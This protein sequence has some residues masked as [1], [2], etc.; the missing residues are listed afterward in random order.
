ML[1]SL[2]SSISG[3]QNHQT[4]MDIIG[5]N[6]ANVNTTGFKSGRITFE[7]SFSQLLQGASRPPGN[8]G[9]TNP[10]QVGLG[11]SIGSIDTM[12]TQGNL[13]A[14]GRMLDLAIEGDAFFGVSDGEGTYFT[15]NGAFQLDYQGHLI[16]PTNGMI[17]QGKMADSY[18]NF[19]AGT[20][21]G[22][23]RVP[24][25]EQSPA[26][27]TETVNFSRNL[28][29]DSDAKGT[30][31]YTQSFLHHTETGDDIRSLYNGKGG[32][33]GIKDGDVITISAYDALGNNIGPSSYTIGVH[34]NTID[35]L[36]GYVAALV[37]GA[38]VGSN[39][40]DPNA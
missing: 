5:N 32:D 19:P 17:L 36:A 11:M 23:I 40:A 13:D 38:N 12:H 6:I 1:R 39:A 20:V 16:L 15:R 31:T 22:D 4:R 8:G 9:G 35:D 14:T 10:L 33:L 28:D 18:G 7:E 29:S 34:I 30:V 24:F 21:V 2:S 3:L 25:N 27:V 26:S 37:G